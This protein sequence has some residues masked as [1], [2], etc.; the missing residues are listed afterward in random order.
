MFVEHVCGPGGL[1]VDHAR[2]HAYSKLKE[3]S[4]QDWII[5]IITGA[6]RTRISP[7]HLTSRYKKL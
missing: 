7:N 5:G 6:D 3:T 2:D 1:R 4:I